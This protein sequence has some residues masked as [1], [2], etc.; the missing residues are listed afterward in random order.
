MTMHTATADLT[1]T[2]ATLTKELR[3]REIAAGHLR[4]IPAKQNQ[5]AIDVLYDRLV[6][7]HLAQLEEGGLW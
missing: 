6:G 3:V 7:L 2:I 4:G 5:T 1:A